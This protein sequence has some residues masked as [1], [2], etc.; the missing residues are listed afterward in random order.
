MKVISAKFSGPFA[1]LLVAERDGLSPRLIEY[2]PFGPL[3]HERERDPIMANADLAIDEI[4]SQCGVGIV[5]ARKA[6]A[7]YMVATYPID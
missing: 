1:H 6:V 4:A 3:P 2:G 7:A 5:E